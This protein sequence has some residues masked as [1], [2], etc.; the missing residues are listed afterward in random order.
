MKNR[1][2]TSKSHILPYGLFVL[3]AVCILWFSKA[4]AACT[5]PPTIPTGFTAP[6]PVFSLS[7]TSLTQSQ[8]LTL[9]ATPQPGTDYLYTTAY[10]SQGTAWNPYTLQGNK[11]YPAY[12]SALA[13]L[14]LSS[15]Q[16]Q[17]LSLGTHYAVVWDWLW[18]ATANCYKGPGLNQCNTGQWRIQSFSLTSSYTYSQSSYTAY[19]YS[20]SS[21]YAYSQSAYSPSCLTSSTTW[22]NQAITSQTGSF[23]AT[24]D[25]TPNANLMD[26]DMGLSLNAASSY[27][28]LATIVEFNSSGNIT[29]RN[30]GSYQAA[31]SIPYGA[32]STYHF[33]LDI[34]IPT[35]TYSIYVTP[36]GQTEKTIGLNYSFRTEQAAVASLN[37]FALV[38]TSGSET[39]CNLTI[40]ALSYAYSQSSYYAYSQ[41]AYYAYSQSSYYAY[42]QSS[43]YAYSQ[44]AYVSG[45]NNYYITTT[46]SDSNPCTQTSPC[47]TINSVDSRLGGSLALGSGGTTIHLASGT[48]TFN[49]LQTN[50]SG[51]ATARIRYISDTRWGAKIAT[52]GWVQYGSY[53]DIVGFDISG[54]TGAEYGVIVSASEVHILGNRIHDFPAPGCTSDGGGGVL[55]ETNGGFTI[56]GN[57]IF[58]IGYPNATPPCYRVHGLYIDQATT[59][60]ISNNVIFNNAALGMK[61]GNDGTV[62]L[63]NLTVVN[64]TVYGNDFGGIYLEG[65]EPTVPMG[66]NLVANN[67]VQHNGWNTGGGRGIEEGAADPNVGGYIGT[68]T[69]TDNLEY[70]N[71]AG[72]LLCTSITSQ[73][74]GLPV[75]SGTVAASA[76]MVSPVSDFHLTSGS[77]AKDKGASNNAPSRDFDGGSRPVNTYY[78]IGAYEYGSTPAAWPWY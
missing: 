20:Q 32:G 75:V 37:N 51:T 74:E 12:S 44:S 59:G 18:D 71:N 29:A 64:N 57:W 16:L 49:P 31:S 56:S 21:Y 69:Y 15:T 50:H 61:L 11:A 43:Y 5:N 7:S 28:N 6:C 4:H 73:C 38:D 77:P 25:A 22:Q 60:L 40:S 26:G 72:D 78:D 2:Y 53:V 9:S 42:S 13:S 34:A 46:G 52:N 36:P 76:L 23:E 48:Y 39:V 70:D 58:H 63:K 41:S 47:L 14:T 27:T 68:N 24:F 33:R 17:S 35:R 1:I 65:G 10:V 30:G 67:I 45:V 8:T 19:T 54:V 62:I 66:G 3:C 55:M